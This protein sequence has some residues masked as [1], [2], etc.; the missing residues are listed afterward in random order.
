ML[1]RVSAGECKFVECSPVWQV[2][3]NDAQGNDDRFNSTIER[4]G[5]SYYPV[6]VGL[7][8]GR[9]RAP[10]INPVVGVRFLGCN[11]RFHSLAT[12]MGVG[13]KRPVPC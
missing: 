7:N 9:F 8:T 10:L 13:I 12:P 11:R 2:M 6:L 3:D 4:S 1:Q 5:L